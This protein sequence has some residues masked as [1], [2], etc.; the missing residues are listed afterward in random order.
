MGDGRNGMII[1][2]RLVMIKSMTILMIIAI[3]IVTMIDGGDDDEDDD[4]NALWR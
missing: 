2:T 1:L 3:S 4:H